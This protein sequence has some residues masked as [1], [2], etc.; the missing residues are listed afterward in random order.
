MI[1]I[2]YLQHMERT[3]PQFCAPALYYCNLYSRRLTTIMELKW[4]ILNYFPFVHCQMLLL[5]QCL[6]LYSAG[7]ASVYSIKMKP[8]INFN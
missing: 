2:V 1:I 5:S 3:V 7:L 4:N 8:I 6:S